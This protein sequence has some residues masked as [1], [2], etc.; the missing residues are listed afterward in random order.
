MVAAAAWRRKTGEASGRGWVSL[1]PRTGWPGENRAGLCRDGAGPIFSIF[2]FRLVPRTMETKEDHRE[3]KREKII[4][5]RIL[6]NVLLMV[7][8]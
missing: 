2:P 3:K 4:S 1:G 5:S 7:E 6:L 8:K